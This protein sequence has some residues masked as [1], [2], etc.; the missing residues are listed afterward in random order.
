MRG[1]FLLNKMLEIWKVS[2]K[3]QV[4]WR[5]KPPSW[6]HLTQ[7]YHK[8]KSYEVREKNALTRKCWPIFRVFHPAELHE[9]DDLLGAVLSDLR[10]VRPVPRSYAQQQMLHGDGI[11]KAKRSSGWALWRLLFSQAEDNRMCMTL[12]LVSAQSK[13]LAELPHPTGAEFHCWDDPTF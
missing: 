3:P 7:N 13:L 2:L 12:L 8:D 9:V 11:Y 6:H 4:F 1:I 5:L 10:H